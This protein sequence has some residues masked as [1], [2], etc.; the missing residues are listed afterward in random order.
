MWTRCGISVLLT[1]MLRLD[2]GNITLLIQDT[3]YEGRF[4]L[5]SLARGGYCKAGSEGKRVCSCV[6]PAMHSEMA[7]A[8]LNVSTA[9][10]FL[11]LSPC[12]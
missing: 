6:G 1:L 2:P 12:A 3:H 8:G 11:L 4:C 10:F 7:T 5:L 9:F